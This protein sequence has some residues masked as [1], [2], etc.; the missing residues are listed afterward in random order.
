MT[1]TGSKDDS[2]N[3]RAR[4]TAE[5]LGYLVGLMDPHNSIESRTRCAMSLTRYAA[6]AIM[7][8]RELESKL[9]ALKNLMEGIESQLKLHQC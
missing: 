5:I 1:G 9:N 4:V 6:D 7:R 8:Q 3:E 2:D